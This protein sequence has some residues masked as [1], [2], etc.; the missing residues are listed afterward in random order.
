[1]VPT[2]ALSRGSSGAVASAGA[3]TSMVRRAVAAPPGRTTAG[4]AEGAKLPATAA[5]AGGGCRAPLARGPAARGRA[6][7]LVGRSR[8]AAPGRGGH[9]HGGPGAEHA[10][11]GAGGLGPAPAGLVLDAQHAP[12]VGLVVHRDAA[13]LEPQ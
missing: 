8:G 6:R 12:P 9:G 2:L 13:A 1:M 3:V 10:E 5:A 4:S 7:H 11:A